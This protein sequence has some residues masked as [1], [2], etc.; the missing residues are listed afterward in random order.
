MRK[1]IYLIKN[2]SL[3]IALSYVTAMNVQANCTSSFCIKA[4]M[5]LLHQSTSKLADYISQR[6]RNSSIKKDTGW[7]SP[8]ASTMAISGEFLST[9]T[10]TSLGDNTLNSIKSKKEVKS[11][12]DRTALY[13]DVIYNVGERMRTN[14]RKGGTSNSNIN[15]AFKGIYQRIRGNVDKGFKSFSTK[16][17]TYNVSYFKSLISKYTPAMVFSIYKVRTKDSRGR[18]SRKVLAGHSI[19]VNGYEGNYLKIYDPWGRIYNVGLQ[20]Q[21]RK[22]Y[23]KIVHVKGTKGSVSHYNSVSNQQ[24]ELY[25]SAYFYANEK[26]QRITPPRPI[27]RPIYNPRIYTPYRSSQNSKYFRYYTYRR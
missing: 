22:K 7:C 14:W 21:G 10:N 15:K 1:S 9:P 2:L 19:A 25:S 11:K 24:A 8:V 12:Y 13:A 26:P 18:N 20:S 17:N 6:E 16:N 27:Y 4:D 3:T 23:P 5:P